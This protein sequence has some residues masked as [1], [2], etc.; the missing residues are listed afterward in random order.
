MLS[1]SD[2]DVISVLSG[3]CLPQTMHKYKKGLSPTT[4]HLS[5]EFRSTQTRGSKAEFKEQSAELDNMVLQH[6]G[7]N[8]DT[9]YGG[10]G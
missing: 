5:S 3:K 4:T 8:M 1:G 6:L 9:N 7:P 10:G 2:N